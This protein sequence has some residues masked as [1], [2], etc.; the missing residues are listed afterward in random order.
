MNIDSVFKEFINVVQ[1]NKKYTI[2]LLDNSGIVT[3]CSDES[4]LGTKRDFRH[5]D[6]HN[7]FYPV[8]EKNYDYGWLWL[9]GTDENLELMGNLISDSLNIRLAYE[10]SQNMLRQNVTEDDRLI[11]LLLDEEIFDTNR[12]LNLVNEMG[13]D[14]SRSR[15]AI[16]IFREKGFDSRKIERLKLI[17]D[18]E[19][20]LGSLL[21]NQVLLIYKSIPEDMDNQKLKDYIKK[22]LKTL[23]SFDIIGDSCWVGSVQNKLRNYQES[24][25]HCLWLKDYVKGKNV[26]VVFF[27]DFLYEFFLSRIGLSDVKGVFDYYRES[28]RGLDID[29]LIRISDS[30]FENNFNISQTAD[31][32]YLHKNTLVYKLKK[33]EESFH[34]DIRGDF[35]GRCLF[36]LIAMLMKEQKKRQQVGEEL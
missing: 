26:E 29:E 12:I 32:L 17:P 10:I 13:F 3:N 15:V 18:G 2:G 27:M 23:R 22:Y 28:S 20:I 4:V 5:R 9:Y 1:E 14:Q 7:L 36:V 16:Y 33:Y 11:R 31:N 24:Y 30:L 34:I 25:R 8:K 21:D 35:K 19:E 6:E